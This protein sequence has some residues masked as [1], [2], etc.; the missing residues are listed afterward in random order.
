MNL[1]LIRR[2]AE[3]AG[4]SPDTARAYCRRGLIEPIKDSAGRRLFTDADI[5]RL[6]EIFRHNRTAQ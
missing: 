1:Y 6:Q 5:R 3:R 4:I 2:A